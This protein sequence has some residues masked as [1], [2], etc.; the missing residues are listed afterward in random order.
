MR[1]RQLVAAVAVL[2]LFAGACSNAKSTGGAPTAPTTSNTPTT[3]ASQTDLTKNVDR[4]GVKGVNGTTIRVAVIT[5]K[6]NPLGGKYHEYIDGIKAYF[7]TI[8]DAGGIYGRQLVIAADRDDNVGLL[9][10]QMTT[11]SLA[12]DNAF[13]TFEATQQLTGADQ[14]A[15][16]GMPTFIWNINP[17]MASTPT[18]DHSNIFGTTGAICFNCPGPLVPWVAEQAGLTKVAVLGYGVSA[19]SKSCATGTRDAYTNDGN[20]K[21]KVVYFDANLGF[22]ADLAAD[23]AKMKQAGVQFVSTCMDNNET[24]KLANEMKKQGLHA[25]QNMPN[26]YDHSFIAQNAAVLDGSFV[27]PLNTPWES[28][29]Q[30]PAT[31]DYLK[32][33]KAVTNDPVELTELG[34]AMAMMFVDGLKGSGPEFT[35]QKVIDYLN[36]QTAY[37]AQGLLAPIDWTTGHVDPQTHPEV[38]AKEQCQPVLVIKSGKMEMFKPSAGK[39]WTCLDTS[40]G[41]DQTPVMKSFAPGGQG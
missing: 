19:E 31:H 1:N 10:T 2:I 14:L 28:E 15:K 30:S 21:L 25:V 39:P 18:Q 36:A 13:A 26:S 5:A 11:A 12:N 20:G 24:L 16:A 4:P 23:V 32:S 3:T 33:I 8:N 38:R 22:A 29:P 17:E 7:K 9:N 41:A 27:E 34:W 37:T 6:T 40:K 35:Q